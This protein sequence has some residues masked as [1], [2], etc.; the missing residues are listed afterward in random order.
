MK[1]LP[2]SSRHSRSK[3]ALGARLS[4]IVAITLS[5]SLLSACSGVSDLTKERVANSATAVQQTEQTLGRSEEGMVEL[6]HAKENLA[7]A[8][9]AVTRA[10]EKSAQRFA[11]KAQLHAELAVAQSQN[12]AARRAAEEVLASTNALRKEA[13]RSNPTPVTP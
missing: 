7:A 9:A 6:Q 2:S 1:H 10:D 11:S 8:Q 3:L 4:T 5:A 13:E 12:A